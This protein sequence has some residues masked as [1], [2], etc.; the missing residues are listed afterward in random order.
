MSCGSIINNGETSPSPLLIYTT[1][2]GRVQI[3]AQ[4]SVKSAL[5]TRFRIWATQTLH[6][7]IRKDFVLNDERLKNPVKSIKFQL[8]P[9]LRKTA[10]PAGC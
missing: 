1:A 9:C 2:D 7:Y 3:A 8:S 4:V 6:E 10:S 5:A